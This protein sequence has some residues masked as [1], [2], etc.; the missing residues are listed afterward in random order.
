MEPILKL[1]VKVKFFDSG[2]GF[3]FFSAD[4]LPDAHVSV[5]RV[6]EDGFSVQDMISD[7]PAV[8]DYGQNAQT[9]KFVALKIHRIGDKLPQQ[10]T[11][12]EPTAIPV[13]QP[14]VAGDAKVDNNSQPM[15]VRK[16]GTVKV[17]DTVRVSFKFGFE[18]EGKTATYG[19]FTP[20]NDARFGGCDVFVYYEDLPRDFDELVAQE[21]DLQLTV[22]QAGANY[23]GRVT[24]RWID[25]KPVHTQQSTDKLLKQERQQVRQNRRLELLARQKIT[26]VDSNNSKCFGIPVVGQEW[27]SVPEGT[28][29]IQVESYFDGE[30]GEPLQHFQVRKP[31]GTPQKQNLRSELSWP[32]VVPDVYEPVQIA[33][34]PLVPKHIE[35]CGTG[36]F[37]VGED[38]VTAVIFAPKTVTEGELVKKIAASGQFDRLA[39]CDAQQNYAL[40]M[41]T[42]D[43]KL[44]QQQASLIMLI[45]AA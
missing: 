16:F 41:V 37:Q 21:V 1:T 29:C 36:L 35:P 5:T 7:T 25:S 28:W 17:G 18:P 45:N 9:G 10:V 30:V 2:K 13:V 44:M 8:V 33:S 22:T 24:G 39:L 42:S 27:E 20:V 15:P 38:K 4:G 32:V 11:Q 19:F 40:G 3:G 12:T 26:V 14:L 34:K 43:G 6:Q 23:N 31:G